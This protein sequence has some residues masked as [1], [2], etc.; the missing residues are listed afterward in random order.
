M[1]LFATRAIERSRLAGGVAG[2]RWAS[3]PP[4]CAELRRHLLVALTTSLLPLL[5]VAPA[6]PF[7][8]EASRPTMRSASAAVSATNRSPSEA[9]EHLHRGSATSWPRSRSATPAP[10]A[11]T[12]GPTFD[13]D[14]AVWARI[15]PSQ[16]DD[17]LDPGLP[18]QGLDRRVDA[19]RVGE[20]DRG[21]R[22]TSLQ[23]VEQV[24]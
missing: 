7:D 16:D 1:E 6:G 17:L 10:I 9:E 20:V 8:G 3:P 18:A 21:R 11:A 15:G 4:R 13:R 2:R 22:A 14:A 24:R 19:G 23:P 12:S 5:G